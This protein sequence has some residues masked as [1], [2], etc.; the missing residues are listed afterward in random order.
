MSLLHVHSALVTFPLKQALS[1]TLEAQLLKIG[2]VQVRADS[3][4]SGVG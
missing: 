2:A 3:N 4:V 1:I